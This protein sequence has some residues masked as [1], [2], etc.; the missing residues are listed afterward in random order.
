M[1]EN[2]LKNDDLIIAFKAKPISKSKNILTTA[3]CKVYVKEPEGYRQVG[4]I[5]D[6]RVTAGIN[7]IMADVSMSFP[8]NVMAGKQ[9]PINSMIKKDK[10]ALMDLGVNVK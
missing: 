4:L 9:T 6:L 5:Q 1:D 8:K 2:I 10:K 7:N 3:Q